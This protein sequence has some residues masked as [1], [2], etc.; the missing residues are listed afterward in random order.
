MLK[1]LII[2]L[3]VVACVLAAKDSEDSKQ[4]ENR[5]KKRFDSHLRKHGKRYDS[6]P[7]EVRTRRRENYM[8]N[9]DFIEKHNKDPK[10]KFQL[11]SNEYS[12]RDTQ[13][14]VDDM[15]RTKLPPMARALPLPPSI[16]A[17][18]TAARVA[19]DWRTQYTQDVVN[20]GACGSCWAFATASTIEA[21]NEIR[22][23]GKTAISQQN[24]V[25]CDTVDYGCGGGWPKSSFD[26]LKNTYGNK[27]ATAMNYAYTSG[28][29]Q[30]AGSCKV[31]PY[32][33]LNYTSTFQF[34]ING[35]AAALKQIISNYGPV[36]IAMYVSPSG[37]FQNYKT[38]IFTD[39]D[40]P[41]TGTNLCYT[42][43]HGMVA[44]GYGST[45]GQEYFII[46]NSWGST[47][48][49]GGYMRMAMGNTCNV[50]CWAMGVE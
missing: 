25:D 40:C 42:V 36:A 29:T 46:R 35:N 8:K 27:I 10:N 19:V 6:L 9:L 4:R 23:R 5:H 37:L 44:V 49:E 24:I 48:G 7:E 22:G 32:V 30:A 20:Q 26:F 16:Y 11:G 39:P 1:N 41:V 31:A 34:L 21:F 2:L 3:M 33:P 45:A 13:R 38:G 18:T 14:F 50:A 28:S 15:C 12:D 47:W 17:T 43:N